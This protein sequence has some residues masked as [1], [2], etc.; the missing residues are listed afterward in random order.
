ME[1][2]LLAILLMLVMLVIQI[3]LKSSVFLIVQGSFGTPPTRVCYSVFS[4]LGSCI[5]AFYIQNDLNLLMNHPGLIVRSSS[6]H[7]I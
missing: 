5:F 2:K 4:D 6:V 7:A 1:G 3:I